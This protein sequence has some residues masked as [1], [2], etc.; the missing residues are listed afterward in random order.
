MSNDLTPIA[1]TDRLLVSTAMSTVDHAAARAHSF[2]MRD[3]T[4]PGI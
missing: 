3:T 4:I 2:G 1:P